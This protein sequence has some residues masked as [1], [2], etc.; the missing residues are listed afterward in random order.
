MVYEIPSNYNEFTLLVKVSTDK[1]EKLRL[2]VKDADMPDTVFTNR[3]K[4]VNG[5]QSF[6]VRMPVSGKKCYLVIYNERVGNVSEDSSFEVL[7]VR[8]IPLEKKMDVIDFSDPKLKTIVKFCTKFC[9]NAGELTSG[10][11]RSRNGEFTIQYLTAIVHPNGVES[12]TPA[13]IGVQ[14]GIIQVSQSKFK[15]MTVPMRMAILLHE[16]C[17]FHVNDNMHDETE[18][19]LNGLLIY[20]GLGYPRIEAYEAFLNT[21]ITVPNEQ[22]KKRYDAIN[23]FINEFEKNNMLVYE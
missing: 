5:E 6:F 8:R 22:N 13:R 18:A 11:Y 12:K 14:S 15:P 17:H 10:T 16:Y 4:T 9:F 1:P 20:L 23:K 2:I 19:D 3:Y 7:D 21:F